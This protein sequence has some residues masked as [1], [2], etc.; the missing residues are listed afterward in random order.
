MDEN[1][2]IESLLSAIGTMAKRT[3]E[4]T[5]KVNTTVVKNYGAAARDMAEAV[6]WLRSPG[7]PHGGSVTTG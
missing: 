1:A 3:E 2:V 5:G 6:A 4:A 7:Q